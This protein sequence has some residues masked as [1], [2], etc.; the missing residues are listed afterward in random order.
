MEGKYRGSPKGAVSNIKKGKLLVGRWLDKTSGAAS[1]SSTSPVGNHIEIDTIIS[2]NV[3]IGRGASSITVAK[4]YCVVDV[5]GKY[6]NK[7][8]MYKSPSNKW[9]KD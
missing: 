3:I 9:K 1:P 5:H 2:A 6:Y 7:W 8:F 4:Y